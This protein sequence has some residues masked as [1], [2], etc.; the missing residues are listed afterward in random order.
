MVLEYSIYDAMSTGLAVMLMGC[1]TGLP[2]IA[3]LSELTGIVRKK[4][5][6]D[7]F[8]AQ[9]A[10]LGLVFVYSV[11]LVVVG[12]WVLSSSYFQSAGVW[13]TYDIFWKT[14]IY[15]SFIASLFFSLYYFL[16]NRLK[17]HKTI[18]IVIGLVG[19]SAMKM[20]LALLFWGVFRELLVIPEVV[21]G[22]D[23]IF[24]PILTQV[25]ILSAGAGASLGL[26]YLLVRR[27]R[28][29]YGRDYY[30]F[31][32]GFG[33]RWGIFF[34]VLSPLTCAWLFLVMPFS[35]DYTYTALPGAVYAGCLVLSSLVLWRI[36]RSPQPLRNKAA[37]VI[38]PVII[39]TVF[40]F[41]MVSYLEF[42]A[43]TSDEPLIQTFV[44]DWPSLY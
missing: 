20:L 39:W 25:F 15:L 33:A 7:K 17:K 24:L 31:A 14:G 30:R 29:D 28:D 13:V 21:P 32:L 12:L 26:V 37:I 2:A 36:V 9:A 22:L 35:F 1:S 34:L 38:C 11:S 40:V 23:S 43:M 10:R 27:N 16:W 41:R 4:V 18:H 5:F 19:L 8:A 42:A 3:L 44:R 6:M